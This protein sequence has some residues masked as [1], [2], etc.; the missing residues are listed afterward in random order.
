MA[1]I[2]LCF[3]PEMDSSYQ[4]IPFFKD[5]P[6]R[7]EWFLAPNRVKRTIVDAKIRVDGGR[8]SVTVDI[9]YEGIE[10][11]GINYLVTYDANNKWMFYFVTDYEYKTSAATTL[12]LKFDVFQSYIFNVEFLDTYV[13]RCHVD[14][15]TEDNHGNIL[16]AG[17][18]VDE[19]L[20]MGDMIAINVKMA[21]FRDKYIIAST[22][23]L[24]KNGWNRPSSGG[25]GGNLPTPTDG[26]LLE[27][28]QNF[29]SGI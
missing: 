24:G 23:P 22:T 3:I 20:A 27:E 9:P 15:F 29:I 5:A 7:N 17:G 28:W 1:I 21:P 14:R 2:K 25:G 6:T 18:T 12:I 26:G 10:R 8:E 16:P 19:G 4:H 11:D 13:D